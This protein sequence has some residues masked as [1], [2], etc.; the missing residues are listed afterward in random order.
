MAGSKDRPSP[1]RVMLAAA[2]ATVFV[3][4]GSVPLSGDE[5]NAS[6]APQDTGH[7][8]EF[9]G[10]SS[11]V[12]VDHL[13]FDEFDAFTIEVWVKAW[14]NMILYEG[15]EGDPENSLWIGWG[16]PRWINGWEANGGEN[17]VHRIDGKT[18]ETWEHLALVFDGKH[19]YFF[20]DGKLL[21]KIPAP[22]PGKMVKERHLLVGAQQKWRPEQTGPADRWGI[23]YLAA[24]RISR[25]ARYTK[26]FTPPAK[27]SNDDDVELLYD[28]SR[29]DEKTLYDVSSK[30]HNGVIHDVTWR[31]RA[32]AD[33]AGR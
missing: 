32:E 20:A 18:S 29:L 24:L 6:V 26:D 23:G 14:Q 5:K 25:K 15:K 11:Y 1:W 19:Q 33:Q 30:K 13:P 8:L 12:D 2:L 4:S 10:Y 17:F 22:K 7:V 27:F 9:N 16:M 3:A 21:H 28:L 31:K